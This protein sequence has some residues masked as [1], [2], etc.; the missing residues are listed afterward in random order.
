MGGLVRTKRRPFCCCSLWRCY[1]T[2]ELNVGGNLQHLRGKDPWAVTCSPDE[3]Y[4]V[5]AMQENALHGWRLRDKGNL[6]MAGYPAKIKSFTWVGDTP[7]LAT[8]GADEAICW[9][10]DGKFGPMERS[11]V[12]VAKNK[13]QIAT[14][15]EAL[16]GEQAVFVGF[17]DGAVLLA[18]ADEF[19]GHCHWGSTGAVSQQLLFPTLALIF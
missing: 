8:S 3:K 18:E 7:H 14:Y 4:L 12:C 10:F 13:K 9:P 15:V 5:T 17:Q 16:A 6:A 19:K 2:S 1:V 11:P